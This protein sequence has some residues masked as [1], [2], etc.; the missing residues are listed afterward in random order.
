MIC[1]KSR[2]GA[3]SERLSEREGRFDVECMEDEKTGAGR[4]TEYQRI[5]VTKERAEGFD[6]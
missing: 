4:I 2:K 3:F 6:M 5:R 1:L